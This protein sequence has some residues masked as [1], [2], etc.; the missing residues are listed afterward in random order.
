[1]SDR[2]PETL[3]QI[4]DAV[5]RMRRYVGERTLA[6]FEAD[7]MAVDA[8]VRTLEAVSEASRDAVLADRIYY[9]VTREIQSLVEALTAEGIA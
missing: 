6:A 3:R 2:D 9:T 1:L 7:E 5:R 4:A 8:V